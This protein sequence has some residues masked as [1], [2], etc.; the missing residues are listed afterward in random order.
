M[1]IYK[2]GLGN[3]LFIVATG[4]ANENWNS[5]NQKFSIGLG[6]STGTAY[7]KEFTTTNK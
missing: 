1:I 3:F 6:C 2:S 4:V 7:T 5:P